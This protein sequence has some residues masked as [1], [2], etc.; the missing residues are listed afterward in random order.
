MLGIIKLN[1]LSL[2]MNIFS[3]STILNYMAVFGF[4]NT[5]MVLK[6]ARGIQYPE[7]GV[8]AVVNCLKWVLG[9]KLRSPERIE[10][11]LNCWAISLAKYG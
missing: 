11:P 1:P 6:E 4:G 3:C 9:T 5:S 8:Q 2:N 7:A 10:T